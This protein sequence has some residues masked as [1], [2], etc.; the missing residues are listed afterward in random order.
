MMSDEESDGNSRKSNDDDDDIECDDASPRRVGGVL[1]T[2][3]SAT[4]VGVGTALG[5]NHP[6]MSTTMT[7]LSPSA[8]RRDSSRSFHGDTF[9]PSDR[10][11]RRRSMYGTSISPSRNQ[12]DS[13]DLESLGSGSSR[14]S[15]P[16][17]RLL[18]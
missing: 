3:T 10:T 9:V 6:T 11:G 5:S 12:S 15:Q 16:Q 8:Q 14:G 1:P 18:T 7:V 4:V 13:S 2:A 17:N